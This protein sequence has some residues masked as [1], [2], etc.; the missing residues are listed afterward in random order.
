MNGDRKDYAYLFWDYAEIESLALSLSKDDFKRYI[1]SI[2][3]RDSLRFNLILRR[4]LERARFQDIFF[5]FELEDIEIGLQRLY[6]WKVISPV[7]L[8]AL[9]HAI[10][11]MRQRQR[12]VHG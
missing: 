9:K 8:H 5:F 12:I 4:F 7:R 10:E 3:D 1:Y 6:L 11:F 2:R